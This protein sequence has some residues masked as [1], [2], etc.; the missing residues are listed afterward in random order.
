MRYKVASVEEEEAAALDATTT[1]FVKQ[2]KLVLHVQLTV[3]GVPPQEQYAETICVRLQ[4]ARTVYHALQTAMANRIKIL[5]GVG[6]A[7]MAEKIQ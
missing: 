7:A 2:E 4:T 6:A 3:L 5:V 1:A